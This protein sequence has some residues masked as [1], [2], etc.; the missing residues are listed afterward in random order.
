[1]WSAVRFTQTG[2]GPVQVIGWWDSACDEPLYLVT[3]LTDRDEACRCYQK[4]MLIETLFSDHKSRG[5][6]HF[7]TPT[8]T[9]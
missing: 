9:A 5:F 7:S 1:M 6:R 8:G 3:N 4:R 2:Y